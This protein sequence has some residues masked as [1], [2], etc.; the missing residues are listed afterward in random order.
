MQHFYY[1][2]YASMENFQTESIRIFSQL[3]QIY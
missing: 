3:L 2:Y 1:V